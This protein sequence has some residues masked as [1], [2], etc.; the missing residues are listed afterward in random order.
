M[1]VLIAVCAGLILGFLIGYIIAWRKQKKRLEPGFNKWAEI[2]AVNEYGHR[3]TAEVIDAKLIK[4]TDEFSIIAEYYD[5]FTSARH[6]FQQAFLVEG[7]SRAFIQKLLRLEN[8]NVL[9]YP[10]AASQISPYWMERPW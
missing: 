10:G 4:G 3:I 7:K 8:V 9:V 2:K 1:D 5:P 6:R